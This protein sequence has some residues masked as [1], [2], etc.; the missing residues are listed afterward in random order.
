MEDYRA[1]LLGR[2]RESV[3]SG[4]GG[5]EPA[6]SRKKEERR[7]AAERR[8]ELAPLKK[9]LAEAE[10]TVSGLEKRKAELEQAIA[11]PGLYTGDSRKLIALQKDIAQVTKDLEAAESAWVSAQEAWDEAHA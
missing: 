9:R 3:G 2:D 10:A 4:K 6:G 7:L 1:R 5:R 11:D 8:N